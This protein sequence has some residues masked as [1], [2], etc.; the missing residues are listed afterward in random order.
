MKKT[1]LIII[2][3]LLMIPMISLMVSTNFKRNSV[4]LNDNDN[5]CEEIN[6]KRAYF[7]NS[8]ETIYIDDAL[9]GVGAHN[10]TWAESKPWCTGEGTSDVP[11]LIANLTINAGGAS[12]GIEILNSKVFFEIR[13]CTVYDASFFEFFVG[14]GIKLINVKNGTLVNNTIFNKCLC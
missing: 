5:K 12:S 9:T 7:N 3:S 8:M 1:K 10:W 13:N 11:Y 4:D 14:V 2:I 6:L